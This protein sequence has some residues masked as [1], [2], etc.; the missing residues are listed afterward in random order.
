MKV[1]EVESWH[2]HKPAEMLF[3]ALKAPLR[4]ARHGHGV[5]LLHGPELRLPEGGRGVPGVRRRDG[6]RRHQRGCE[7]RFGLGVLK[8]AG[9]VGRPRVVDLPHV[10]LQQ[11]SLR[12]GRDG[13]LEHLQPFGAQA[14]YVALEAHDSV[15]QG[16][17]LVRA[18]VDEVL[19]FD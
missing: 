3:R 6:R 5:P 17:L 10:S 16:D 15:L 4:R 13:A 14:L 1:L 11:V 19:V 9:A 7:A 18:I 8:G 12:L 2:I